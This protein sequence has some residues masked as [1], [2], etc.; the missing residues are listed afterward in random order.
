MCVR[1][2]IAADAV[3]SDGEPVTPDDFVRTLAAVT[4]P[5][6]G[7]PDQTGYELIDQIEVIDD[8][9]FIVKFSGIFPAWRTLFDF[10]LPAHSNDPYG[11]E[12]A[13]VTGPFLLED[14]IEGERIVL[15]R[16]PLYWPDTDP[17]SGMRRGDVQELVFVFD[18]SARDQLD[19]LEDGELDV[20]S[21][22]PL[23]WMVEELE[24]MESVSYQVVPGAFWEHIDFNHDDP[25]L[26]QLWVREAISMAI[27][28]ESILD[29]TVRTVDPA[30]RALDSAVW[31]RN[32]ARYQ[33]HFEHV[34]D[35][36]AAVEA[37]EGHFCERGDDGIYECQGRRMS[38]VWAT[39]VGDEYRA[40]IFDLVSE[41][42]AEVGIE[43][44]LE[45]RTPS[46]LFS[47]S[48]FFGGPDVWQLIS[49]S[50]RGEADPFRSNSVF[51]CEGD[52]PS[53]HGR[54]NV[55]RYCNQEVEA[56]IRSTEVTV[57]ETERIRAYD[58]ADSIYLADSAIVPLFQ[59]PALLAFDSS[60]TGPTANISASTDLWN[61]ASWSGAD[62][63]VIALESEP[64][65]LD[66]VRAGESARIVLS[67]MLH[68]AFSVDPSLE[69][70]PTLIAD[71]E[72]LVGG[73]SP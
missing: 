27:D 16:N 13:P 11:E 61:V 40:R 5:I 24:A 4:D 15:R 71:A 72:A 30:A 41:D 2:E 7:S 38:F 55:S 14:W 28:R 1:Y 70:V 10:V 47:S 51:Y 53:G 39:T 59:K 44:N 65:T 26:G 67:A 8:R 36:E 69:Y 49:F 63:V 60:I 25:L 34:H 73:V 6:S 3:W 62:S 58:E 57:D 64:D 52:A 17:A 45:A 48:V 31:L 19:G 18:Q 54:L 20:I 29:E 50:W 22:R 32:S 56:L 68:G 12:G 37:L 23:D 35:P 43:V 46:D 33:D 66:P 9:V 42:L 21:P